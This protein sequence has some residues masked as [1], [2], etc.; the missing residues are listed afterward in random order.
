MD[1]ISKVFSKYPEL[2]KSII[3]LI[4]IIQ[5]NT[6]NLNIYFNKMFTEVEQDKHKYS[7][8]VSYLKFIYKVFK[9]DFP[10]MILPAEH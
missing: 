10:Y 4:L 1:A 9:T 5:S 6:Q 7:C 2:K 3:D 8:T